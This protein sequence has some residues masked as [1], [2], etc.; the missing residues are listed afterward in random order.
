MLSLVTSSLGILSYIGHPGKGGGLG[1]TVA[2]LSTEG[3]KGGLLPHFASAVV[4]F[5][6]LLLRGL[7]LLLLLR[8]LELELRLPTLALVALSPLLAFLLPCFS[9][10][11]AFFDLV[12]SHS[13][14]YSV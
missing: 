13:V 8:D 11:V 9:A 3:E 1:S 6:L 7:E 4:S 14:L 5:H 2:S 10:K 12:F